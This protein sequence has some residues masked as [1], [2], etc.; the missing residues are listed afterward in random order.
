MIKWFVCSL[1]IALP[2]AAQGT[3][4]AK[5]EAKAWVIYA[6][7]V[8][9]GT[10][11][12][13][14]AGMVA[15]GNGKIATV[16]PS[17]GSD[18]DSSDRVLRCFAVTPGLIDASVRITN[19]ST[20]VEQSDE[21]QPGLR[22]ATSLDPFSI[23]WD[24]QVRNGV[25]TVLVSAPDQNVIGGLSVVLKTAGAES[26]AARTVKNDA[27]LRGSMG[28]QPSQG[29][30]PAFGRPTDFYSRRPT[31][32]MGVE[33]AWRKAFYDAAASAA[34]PKRAFNGSDRLI[35][36][37]KGDLTVSIQAWATQDIRTA[38]FLKE[39]IESQDEFKNGLNKPRFFLDAAAEAWKEPQLLVRSKIPVVLPPFPAQGRTRDNAFMAWNTAEEL[40]K[41]GVPF[42]LSSHG[43]E[44]PEDALALQAGYAMM[45]GLPFESALAAVTTIPARLMGVADRVGT[46]EVGKD[47]D[48]VLWNGAPFE[49]SSRVI[50]VIVDGVMRYDARP[51]ESAK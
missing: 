13:F 40:R 24:R 17:R 22:V 5:P 37:L 9:T 49:P 35:A 38:V 34:D 20:S 2:C 32:R 23:A 47:A 33:W 1:A 48:L 45:G 16:S 42:A 43:S 18:D 31:T 4:E 29:N 10:G 14:E 3:P 50:A 12:D 19:G 8:Y 25:T 41:Q 28:T 36:A 51:K 39:E 15:V 27:V 6:D 26:I 7:R 21:I 44:S 46:L 30:H 11:T